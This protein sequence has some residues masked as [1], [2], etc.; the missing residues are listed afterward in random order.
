VSIL[1]KILAQFIRKYNEEQAIEF[2]CSL[3]HGFYIQRFTGTLRLSLFSSYTSEG[4]VI[5]ADVVMCMS[6][7]HDLRIRSKP[8]MTI[9][10][11]MRI[12]VDLEYQEMSAT[13]RSFIN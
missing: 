11:Y 5:K 2:I 7:E 13:K 9:A 8:M 6:T 10:S 4:D 12:Y 3:R 1:T